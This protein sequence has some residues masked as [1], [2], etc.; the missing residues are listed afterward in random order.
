[1]GYFAMFM[2]GALVGV[3]VM[4]LANAA[5]NVD[6]DIEQGLWC[7]KYIAD[8]RRQKRFSKLFDN[9]QHAKDKED[10]EWMG[11]GTLTVSTKDTEYSLEIL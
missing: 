5:H 7:V 10:I 1:M 4:C 2:L 8:A 11:E 3:A 6:S 9:M